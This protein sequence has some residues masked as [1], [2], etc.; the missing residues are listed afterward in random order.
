M[1]KALKILPSPAPSSAEGVLS[2]QELIHFVRKYSPFYKSLY[3]DL[4]DIL[5]L[6]D[7]PLTPQDAFWAANTMPNSKVLTSHLTNG[8]VLRSGGTTGNPKFSAFS[9]AEWKI[10]TETTG[11]GFAKGAIDSGDVLANLFPVGNMYGSFIF[12]TRY[13]ESCPT[14]VV[15]LPIASHV[16]LSEIPQILQEFQANA[17]ATVPTTLM[18]F[19]EHIKKNSPDFNFYQIKKIFFAGEPLFEDQR[20]RLKEIFPDAQVFSIGYASVDAGMLGYVD[21]TCT[22]HE[23]R[24]FSQHTVIEIIDEKTHEVIEKENQEGLIVVTNLYRKLMPIIRYPVG[25]RGMWVE[26]KGSPDRKF[27]LLGRSEEAACVGGVK[28]YV[29]D[30]RTL[31]EAYHERLQIVDFQLLTLHQSKRDCLVIKIASRLPSQKLHQH[32]QEI[33]NELI[34]VRPLYTE[35]INE[36]GIEPLQIEW[37]TPDQLETNPRTGKLRRVSDKRV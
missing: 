19:A 21:R 22:V 4:P 32:S 15:Q 12:T 36:G 20:K 3:K 13:I 31:L 7:L 25:D 9:H 37:I 16:E 6:K 14:N 8:L 11:V 17:I 35:I 2:P 24:V 18:N 30:V 1:S 29:H 26:K 33:I 27:K 34:R 5:Q 23:H 10:Y 28:F